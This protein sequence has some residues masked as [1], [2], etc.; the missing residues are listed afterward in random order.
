MQNDTRHNDAKHNNTQHNDIEQNDTE[1]VVMTLRTATLSIKNFEIVNLSM[2]T[3]SIMAVGITTVSKIPKICCTRH[4]AECLLSQICLESLSHV[5]LSRK[6]MRQV[7]TN[8]SQET[9]T[10][11]ES[12]AQLFPFGA[13]GL[14][15]SPSL[16]KRH[17][18]VKLGKAR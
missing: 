12:S 18:K 5:S 6:S 13:I 2:T 9:P 11:R 3:L 10:H 14:A 16:H 7:S 8:A 17:S 4:N 1:V 15:Y